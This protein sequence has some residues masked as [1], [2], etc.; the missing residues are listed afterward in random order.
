MDL[1]DIFSPQI[2]YLIIGKKSST[3][4]FIEAKRLKV[5]INQDSKTWEH[6]KYTYQLNDFTHHKGRRHKAYFDLDTQQKLEWG[7]ME[8]KNIDVDPVDADTRDARKLVKA[9]VK[10]LEGIFDKWTL[11]L[12]AGAGLGIGCFVGF[13]VAGLL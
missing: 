6:K 10:E 8:N 7:W 13:I 11:I 5:N 1:D 9:G 4:G 12:A 2:Y 3:N